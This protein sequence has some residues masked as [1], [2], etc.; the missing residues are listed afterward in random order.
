MVIAIIVTAFL[1][2]LGTS[3]IK[4]AGLSAKVK[5]VIA[6]VLSA[7]GAGVVTVVTGGL[8]QAADV[9]DVSDLL[10][11]VTMVYGV[12]QVI[13]HFLLDGTGVDDS[14][15]RSLTGKRED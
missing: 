9:K 2:V 12:S 6:I 1:V 8:D 13:Y 11:L 14:L 4:Y 15:E 7:V 10:A 3:L 5:N